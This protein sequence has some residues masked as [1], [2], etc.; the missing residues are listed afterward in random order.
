EN[1]DRTRLDCFA[2]IIEPA[3]QQFIQ[4]I[5]LFHGQ[6]QWPSQGAFSILLA[7]GHSDA[8]ARRRSGGRPACRRGRHLA[9][10]KTAWESERLSKYRASCWNRS[11]FSPGGTPGSTAGE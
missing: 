4:G 8:E 7:T 5:G 6:G 11:L 2:T 3:H 9:A 10:R 1:N